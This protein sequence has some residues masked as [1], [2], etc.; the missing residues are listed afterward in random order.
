MD[1]NVSPPIVCLAD[2]ERL[3]E[4]GGCVL[5]AGAEDLVADVLDRLAALAEV[6]AGRDVAH[7]GRC[8]SGSPWRSGRG[9]RWRLGSRA[10]RT[11][12]ASR[13]PAPTD[14]SRSKVTIAWFAR[15]EMSFRIGRISGLSNR[16]SSAA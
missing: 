8:G 13:P 9:R 15:S 16:S 5:E 10:T 4:I 11:R 6:A 7:G 1:G 12:R 3:L 14:A 2:L